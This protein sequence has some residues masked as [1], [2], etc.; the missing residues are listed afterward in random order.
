MDTTTKQI[1]KKKVH[2]K[3]ADESILTSLSVI[4]KLGLAKSKI[5]LGRFSS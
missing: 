3:S 4:P 5:L 2:I 1:D